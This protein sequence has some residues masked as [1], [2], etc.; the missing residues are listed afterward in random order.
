MIFGKIEYLN[1][2]PF[3]IFLKRYLRHSSE[4]KAWQLRGSVP[5]QI[6]RAF[7]AK[8]VDAAVIS[9][10]KSRRYHCSD[11]GIVADGEVQSVLLI[12]G[13]T[14]TD[15]ESD[16]SNQLAKVLGLQGKIIIGD[17][18]LRFWLEHPDSAID[19]AT[20]WK[21]QE[22]LPFVFARLCAHPPHCQRIQKMTEAF[23]KAPPKI[24][25]RILRDAAHK[26]GLTPRQLQNYLQHIYY[27]LGWREKR[28]LYRF[29]TL[30][31]MHKSQKD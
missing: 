12:P 18:A 29:F 1:L 7:I 22:G 15:K 2:L 21:A 14:Q 31:H 13:D 27:K 4:K 28:A 30:S 6:N 20:A 16:T 8:R 5:S 23:F 9:S 11:F 17:K 25:Y 26:H 24:P 10:I 3:H 19:L